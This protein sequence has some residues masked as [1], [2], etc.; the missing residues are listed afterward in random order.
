MRM[1]PFSTPRVNATLFSIFILAP[2]TTS[3]ASDWP[4]YRGP[5]RDGIS[6]EEGIDI[7]GEAEVVWQVNVGLGYSSP[8][9]SQGKV[10]ISGHDGAGADTVY[11]LDAKSGSVIW[12][13]SY[14]QPLG[15]RYFQGG[16]TGTATFKGDRVYHL[17]RE[18]ELFC[19]NA[20][21]GKVEWMKHLQ[22]DFG[23]T[24]PEWGFTGAPLVVGDRVFLTAG[25]YGVALDRNNGSPIWKSP[26]EVAGYATPFPMTVN[27]TDYL[28]F[29]NKRFYVCV[30][31]E[32]GAEV[33]RWRWM[34]RYGVN[35]ADPVVVGNYILISSGYGKG[36]VLL[37]WNG[38]GEPK[39]IWQNR[40]LRTQMNAAIILGEYI[41]GIDGNESVDGTGLKCLDLKTGETLWS[42]T[43]VGHGTMT[44]QKDQLIVL[45]E[46]GILQI[47]PASPSGYK[48]TFSQNVV[49]PRVWTV[50][51]LANGKIYCRNEAGD[52]AVVDVRKDS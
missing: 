9:I 5:D 35:S 27:G 3:E 23:Y 33:W 21:D 16:T 15:D 51:V 41:Y 45:T 18:G 8:V 20:A 36:A 4:H 17:A 34:T 30:E 47:A 43:S 31:A 37:E 6:K 10:V 49:T 29:S 24:K 50:P 12:K 48:P 40:E 44:A 7:S 32:S 39:K 25:E 13:H 1:L 52:L 42:E 26:D 46:N 19:F 14:P 28:I 38:S 11:C 2:L 22:K